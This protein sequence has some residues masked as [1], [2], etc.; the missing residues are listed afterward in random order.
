[1]KKSND[2]VTE[3]QNQ[4]IRNKTTQKSRFKPGM[5]GHTYNPHTQEVEARGL[6][7]VRDQPRIQ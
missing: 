1:M 4:K 2:K 3:R 6:S 5:V 7:R